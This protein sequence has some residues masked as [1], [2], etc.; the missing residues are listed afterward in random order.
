VVEDSL[1]VLDPKRPIRE[2]DIV[3]VGRHVS[4]VPEATLQARLEAEVGHMGPLPPY[5]VIAL[6]DA[7][8][9]STFSKVVRNP[10]NPSADVCLS[11]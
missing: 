7:S 2:A 11:Q 1:K 10:F 5:G 9:Y 8:W 4:K 3:T 6:P